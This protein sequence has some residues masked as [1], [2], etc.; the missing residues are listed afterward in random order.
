[1]SS[2]WVPVGFLLS[3]VGLQFGQFSSFWVYGL[4]SGYVPVG[5]FCVPVVFWLS[6]VEPLLGSSIVSMVF[7]GFIGG[8]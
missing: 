8:T 5:S 6:S 2:G 1:M 7:V 4:G 3:L